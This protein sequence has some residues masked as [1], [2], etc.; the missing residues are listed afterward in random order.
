M[1]K[2]FAV[3]PALDAG[4]L[5]AQRP[6]QFAVGCLDYLE[7]FEALLQFLPRQVLPLPQREKFREVLDGGP[8]N[9]QLRCCHRRGDLASSAWQ[10][11]TLVGFNRITV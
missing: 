7:F 4:N 1:G 2:H 3:H 6:N 8:P 11:K 5:Q 10:V 9:L